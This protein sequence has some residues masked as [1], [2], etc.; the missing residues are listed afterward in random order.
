M[1]IV[2]IIDQITP[3]QTMGSREDRQPRILQLSK[4]TKYRIP[5]KKLNNISYY[6]KSS[7]IT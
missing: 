6:I 4:I 3:K 7:N 2:L 1:L 5:L